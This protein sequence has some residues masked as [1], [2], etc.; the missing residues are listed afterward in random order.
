M[1]IEVLVSLA[2]LPLLAA[3]WGCPQSGSATGE[4]DWLV[5]GETGGADVR[6]EGSGAAPAPLCPP[7]EPHGVAEG[8]Y[9]TDLAFEV[10]GD[11]LMNLHDW[12]GS[13]LI[14]LYHFYGW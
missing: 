11:G 8:D 12:C 9:F 4:V 14:L 7:P 3:L 13:R 2:F 1:R 10:T 6:P 5:R